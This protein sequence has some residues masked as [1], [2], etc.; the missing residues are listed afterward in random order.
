MTSQDNDIGNRAGQAAAAFV[1]GSD[2]RAG[3]DSDRRT[4]SDLGKTLAE[5]PCL[6]SDCLH[7]SSL[8]N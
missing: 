8:Q 1:F 2:S 5:P 6:P 3:Q 4:T 7:A